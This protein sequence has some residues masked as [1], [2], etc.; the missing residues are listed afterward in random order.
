M[1]VTRSDPSRPP[2]PSAT[3]A[4]I[5]RVSLLVDDPSISTQN[6][7]LVTDAQNE[8]HLVDP[9]EDSEENLLLLDRAAFESGHS[10]EG[11]RSIVVTH[12]H[13]DHLGGA[14]RIRALSG[15]PIIVHEQE[16]AA[17]DV[18]AHQSDDDRRRRI[19]FDDWGV[20]EARAEE[21]LFA[22]PR[23]PHLEADEVLR[24]DTMAVGRTGL[25]AL[26]TP[27]HT[28]G[29]VCLVDEQSG[30][31]LTGDH[32]LPRVNPGI[33]LGGP[34]DR[35]P[36][37]DYLR[38]LQRLR[39]YSGHLA[40]PGHGEPFTGLVERVDEIERHH[41]RRAQEAARLLEADP[42]LSVWEAATRLTWSRPWAQFRGHYLAAALFQT[43]VIVDLLRSG[44]GE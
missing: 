37:G 6:A 40:L 2:A 23:P 12:L 34:S 43:S 22:I 25:V 27:G 3:D 16:Q 1:T 11:L 19:G 15:A 10:L 24:G 32:L 28:T 30:S 4:R 21:A 29:H 35:N 44:S 41:R 38:S 7:Y 17:I 33:G 13:A 39:S 20:P 14:Q 9:G 26:H 18:L 36:L 42:G 5:R 8:L 31:I